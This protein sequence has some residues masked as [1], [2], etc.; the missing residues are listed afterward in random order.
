MQAAFNRMD[1]NMYVSGISKKFEG[2]VFKAS[3]PLPYKIS[4]SISNLFVAI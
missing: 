4:R 3:I 2:D 1:V